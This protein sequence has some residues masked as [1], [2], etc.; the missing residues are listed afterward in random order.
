VAIIGLV[1]D[2]CLIM[3]SM[4]S[5]TTQCN[6][7]S[8]TV[9][10]ESPWELWEQDQHHQ[11]DLSEQESRP[12][13]WY[14]FLSPEG[15]EYGGKR[16]QFV[17]ND[18]AISWVGTHSTYLSVLIAVKLKP[19]YDERAVINCVK[20]GLGKMQDALGALWVSCPRAP[21]NGCK[22]NISRDFP[23]ADFRKLKV[24]P[25]ACAF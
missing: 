15:H 8:S 16:S 21:W 24:E 5:L 23:R 14:D 6:N 9:S 22:P 3:K 20:A 19:I 10:T 1:L 7:N 13:W 18:S 4:I 11:I 17:C 2:T 25:L 12:R